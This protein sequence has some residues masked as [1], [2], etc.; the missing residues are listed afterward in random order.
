MIILSN[1]WLI[2]VWKTF[3][4]AI[5]AIPSVIIFITKLVAI[6]NPNVPSNKICDLFQK[7]W[8]FNGP[9]TGEITSSP[10]VPGGPD[11]S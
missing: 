9:K 4:M 7:S 11:A 8:P 5:I 3:S 1:D 10:I 2:W 6:F